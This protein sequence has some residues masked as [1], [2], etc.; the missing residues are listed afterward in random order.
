[1][2]ILR[3]KLGD[4][5]AFAHGRTEVNA[6]FVQAARDLETNRR[7][8]VSGQRAR[9][10]DGADDGTLAGLD[11]LDGFGGQVGCDVAATTSA[12][13]GTAASA[14]TRGGRLWLA[15]SATVK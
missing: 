8:F 1:M 2:K 14:A 13:T 3:F 7:L 9:R 5:L 11:Y 6:Q 10:F 12:A 4:D 15:L